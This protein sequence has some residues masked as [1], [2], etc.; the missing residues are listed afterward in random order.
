MIQ[1]HW[2]ILSMRVWQCEGL[3]RFRV[4]CEDQ[5]RQHHY[6][7]MPYL[8]WCVCSPGFANIIRIQQ[9]NLLAWVEM[10]R[11]DSAIHDVTYQIDIESIDHLKLHAAQG[12]G[13]C[14][15]WMMNDLSFHKRLL[16]ASSPVFR[17]ILN[18]NIRSTAHRIRRDCRLQKLLH[19]DP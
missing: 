4:H 11:L 12:S 10:D 13:G 18:A 16:T 15:R 1:K 7:L 8:L 19:S 14:F 2:T 3:A 6:L 9:Q 5:F 17:G